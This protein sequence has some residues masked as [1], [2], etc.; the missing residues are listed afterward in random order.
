VKE[1][2]CRNE[3]WILKGRESRKLLIEIRTLIHVQ[4]GKSL[5]DYSISRT[6]RLVAAAQ[7]TIITKDPPTANMPRRLH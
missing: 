5:V 6:E 4:V 2:G 3:I 7:A 1:E